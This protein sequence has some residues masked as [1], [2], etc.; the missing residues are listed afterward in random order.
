MGQELMVVERDE[1]CIAAFAAA[2]LGFA[3]EAALPLVR[4]PR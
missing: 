3:A 4:A 1:R 2:H